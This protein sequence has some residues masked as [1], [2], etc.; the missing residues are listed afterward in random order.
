[1]V[2]NKCVRF[3]GYVEIQVRALQDLMV[4]FT[5]E[6]P[7]FARFALPSICLCFEVVLDSP[8]PQVFMN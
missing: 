5:K 7:T 1:M 3:G 6:G 4:G 8:W 2:R